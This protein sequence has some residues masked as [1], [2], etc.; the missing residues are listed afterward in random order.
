VALDYGGPG[1]VAEV[2]AALRELG[3]DYD[4]VRFPDAEQERAALAAAG[5]AEYEVQVRR[6][7]PFLAGE[8]LPEYLRT[9]CL[10]RQLRDLEGPDADRL[11]A[12]VAAR[13]PGGAINY[14]RTEVTARR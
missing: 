1:N 12:D 8:H 13:L 4:E 9:I 14:V 3:R 5:F 11:V 2:G 6:E 7:E 10:G